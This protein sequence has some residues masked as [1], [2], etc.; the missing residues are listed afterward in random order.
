VSQR[1]AWVTGA[2]RGVGRGVAVALGGAGRDVWVTARSARAAGS[3]SH[4]PDS[5]EETALAVTVPHR[6]AFHI[7]DLA[8]RYRINV[9]D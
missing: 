5:V 9:T 1:T 7:A 8:R 3:T 6:K 4:L 2:S